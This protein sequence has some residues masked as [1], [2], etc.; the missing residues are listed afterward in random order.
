MK[1]IDLS[2]DRFCRLLLCGGI[3]T[4]PNVRF[5]TVCRWLDAS[6]R[7]LDRRLRERFG[8]GGEALMELLKRQ[9]TA[10]KRKKRPFI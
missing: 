7:R 4:D 1:P 3:L 8:L 5:R 2:A 10:E 6:P 9:N